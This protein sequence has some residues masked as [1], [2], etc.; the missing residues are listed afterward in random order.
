MRLAAGTD[1]QLRALHIGGYWRGANDMVRQMMLGLRSTGA[2]VVEYNTD[3]HPEALDTEGRHYD[4]GTT[5]LR[6]ARPDKVKVGAL[7][8][9]L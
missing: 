6:S 1:A 7:L 3:D 5:A 8:E 4:R 2:T 9:S